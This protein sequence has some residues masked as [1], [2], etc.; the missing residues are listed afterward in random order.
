MS[1]LFASSLLASMGLNQP[2]P[3]STRYSS[4]TLSLTGLTVGR[5]FTLILAY[6]RLGPTGFRQLELLRFKVL[7]M[8][9]PT[10][11]SLMVAGLVLLVALWI[12]ALV[13]ALSWFLHSVG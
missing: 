12:W 11:S 13:N 3:I 8:W 5:T 4:V 1:D 2:G 10:A 9:R 7:P 6:S